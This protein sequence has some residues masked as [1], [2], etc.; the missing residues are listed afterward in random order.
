MYTVQWKIPPDDHDVRLDRFIRRKYQEIPLTGIFR[1]LRKGVIRVNGKKKKPAYRLQENDVVRVD[2]ATRPSGPKKL[3]I[4]SAEQKKTLAAA[5]V[6]E[7]ADIALY[8]KP[9]GLAMHAGSG[10]KYGFTEMIQAATRNPSFTF[11]NRIDKATAGLVIGAKN[12]QAARNMSELLRRHE[13]EKIYFT[14]V[15][16]LV[17]EDTFT[18]SSFLK[19]EDTRVEEHASEAQGA[20]KAESLFTVIKRFANNTTLLEARLVTGRTHQL[21]VQLANLSHPIIGDTKYGGKKAKTM[22]LFSGRVVIDAYGID[23][24]LPLPEYFS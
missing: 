19:K 9:P 1:L 11:V 3:I 17:K 8:N 22:L 10:H 6:F 16:G 18:V 12:K 15:H 5:L 7:D 14:M 4:L 20:K 13:V 21:R 24:R 2:I 23:V